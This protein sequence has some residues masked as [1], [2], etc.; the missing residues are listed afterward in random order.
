MSLAFLLRLIFSEQETDNT[1]VE[2]RNPE[3]ETIDQKGNNNMT[4]KKKNLFFFFDKYKF[5]DLKKSETP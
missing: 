4:G 5:I 3:C 2:K 1:K